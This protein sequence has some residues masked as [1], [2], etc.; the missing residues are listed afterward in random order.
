MTTQTI[1][2]P[3]SANTTDERIMKMVPMKTLNR[4]VVALTDTLAIPGSDW[5]KRM[6]LLTRIQMLQ[7][8]IE[9]RTLSLSDGRSYKPSQIAEALTELLGYKVLPSEVNQELIKVDLQA[10]S[11]YENRYGKTY[12]MFVPTERAMDGG[13]VSTQINSVGKTD[14]Q[15]TEGVIYIL[16]HELRSKS[17]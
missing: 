10:V 7:T 13:F 11:S 4:N 15:W 3:L 5:N 8:E 6:E 14:I 17:Q 12:P 9:D 2:A 16:E 1:F